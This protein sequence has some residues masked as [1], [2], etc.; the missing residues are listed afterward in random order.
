MVYAF[1]AVIAI[2]GGVSGALVIAGLVSDLLL[3]WLEHH[4]GRSQRG[5]QA[6]YRTRSARA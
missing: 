4:Q 5:A 6:T 3:P 1:L 2:A